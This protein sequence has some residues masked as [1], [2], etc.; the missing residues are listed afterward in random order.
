MIGRY[1]VDSLSKFMLGTAVVLLVFAMGFRNNFLNTLACLLVLLCYFRMFSRNYQ[2]RAEEN[3]KFLELKGKA[4]TFLK[5]EKEY[6]E[7]RK[8]HHIYKCPSC[9]QKIRVPKGKGKICITCPK[10]HT[11]FIKK[12]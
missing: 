5:R 9:K 6:F 11:E 8:T 2:K 10:C 1:G 3:Q 7:Q 12:S 4:A